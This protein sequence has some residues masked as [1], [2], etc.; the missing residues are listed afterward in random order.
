MLLPCHF[1]SVDILDSRRR[2][3]LELASTLSEQKFN[4]GKAFLVQADTLV[5]FSASK[6]LK[7]RSCGLGEV[8][9]FLGQLAL[10]LKISSHL[11]FRPAGP[12]ALTI[13]AKHFFLETG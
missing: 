11:R 6:S 7:V 2:V 3:N 10:P 4:G 13:E 12:K 1:G 5:K 8:S 9:D